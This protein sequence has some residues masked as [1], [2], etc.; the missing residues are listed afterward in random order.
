MQGDPRQ[1]GGDV[2]V[3]AEGV[4]RLIHRGKDPVDRLSVDRL[5]VDRLPVDRLLAVLREVASV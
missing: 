2:I 1:L 4:I 3:D 5:P